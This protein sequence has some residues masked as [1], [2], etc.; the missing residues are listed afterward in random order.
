MNEDF[1]QYLWKHKKFE[2]SNLKTT[3]Q[4]QVILQFVG[5]HN[6]EN[7]GPDF[8]NAQMSIENQK[9]AGN[10]EIHCKSSDWY[11]HNHENDRAY[12]NVI[13]HVVWEEDAEIFRRDNTKIPTLQLKDYV[14][15]NILVHYHALFEK[16]NTNWIACE[17]QLPEVTGFVVSNW[18]ERLYIERLE[19]KSIL[20]LELLKKSTNNWEAVLFKLLAKN[21]GLKVNGESFLSLAN[22]L[23]FSVIQKCSKDLNRLEALFFG[24]ANLL[25]TKHETEYTKS[26]KKEY[27]FLRNKF[28]INNKGVIP[29][30]FFRLRPP[31]FPTIRLAQLA[32][33][34]C[35]HQQ[36][37]DSI[38]NT[39]CINDF[40][41]L[42]QVDTSDFWKNHY[43]FEKESVSRKKKV[44]QSFINLL[45]INTIIPIKFIYARSQGKNP[46]EEI[47]EL[48]SQLP[49]E[50]NSIIDHFASL[51]VSINNA[52]Q[53]QAMLQ[54][55]NEYCDKK[56]C[57]KCAIGNYLLNQG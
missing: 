44:T 19:Q 51:K 18:Q 14:Q 17:K 1:L 36:L 27:D 29:F 47:F 22:S 37:F 42:F 45:L 21:F 52:M 48:L 9:W 50:K 28:N 56:A 30:Q 3:N 15:K 5:V 23:D 53:S 32:K 54:L 41:Q 25:T 49:F 40:Y 2:L 6:T 31:N 8:F 4:Q 39:N 26:L 16:N 7:S 24:Q 35:S 33:L 11:V 43:T 13:L 12:D 10:V 46:E 34:Y 38:I 57:L 55:K 20:I